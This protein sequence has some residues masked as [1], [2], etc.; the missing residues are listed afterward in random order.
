MVVNQRSQVQILS[1]LPV[2]TGTRRSSE[3]PFWCLLPTDLLTSAILAVLAN[4]IILRVDE[5]R[6]DRVLSRSAHDALGTRHRHDRTA[7]IGA[8]SG[9]A[10]R[11]RH[12]ISAERD[13][14]GKDEEFSYRQ[15][16]GEWLFTVLVV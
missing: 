10:Q 1:P 4:G 3:G 15:G 16:T 8:W 2:E 6:G 7:T 12:L 13:G 9:Q 5:E 14:C 11:G